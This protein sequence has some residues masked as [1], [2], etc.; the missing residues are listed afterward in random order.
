MWQSQG[1]D[2]IL[3]ILPMTFVIHL[4]YDHA[5]VAVDLFCEN[6][7]HVWFIVYC[8]QVLP[9]I[10]SCN[11][12][13]ILYTGNIWWGEILVNHTSKSYWQGKIW[14]IN[15][16]QRIF[17]IYCQCICEYSHQ[18]FPV[19]SISF[20]PQYRVA[21][22]ERQGLQNTKLLLEVHT[23]LLNCIKCTVLNGSPFTWWS[24]SSK[25]KVLYGRMVVHLPCEQLGYVIKLKIHW[26]G[27]S[28]GLIKC[29]GV[30]VYH[31]FNNI[32]V[33]SKHQC[34]CSHHYS[35]WVLCLPQNEQMSIWQKFNYLKLVIRS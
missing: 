22:E 3:L 2:K 28:I 29:V 25:N 5:Q 35:H 17:Q 12:K 21:W 24:F 11:I 23:R 32:M 1:R 18:N 27:W 34:E 8:I 19:Y 14:W 26:V 4:Q 33:F 30:L 9:L 7:A 13:S 6:I 15:Y 31:Q 20:K 16:S 10:F